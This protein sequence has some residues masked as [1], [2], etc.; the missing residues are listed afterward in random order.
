VWEV[1]FYK[2]TD[3]ISCENWKGASPVF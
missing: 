2:I 3:I 1:F